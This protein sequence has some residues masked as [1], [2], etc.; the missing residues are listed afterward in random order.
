M[1]D[2]ARPRGRGELWLRGL[3]WVDAVRFL[4]WCAL[5]SRRGRVWR[6]VVDHAV[7]LVFLVLVLAIYVEPSLGGEEDNP[8]L[9]PLDVWWLLAGV[10]GANALTLRRSAPLA[11]AAVVMAMVA[12]VGAAP[13][14]LAPVGWMVYVSAFSLGRYSTPLRSLAGLGLFAVAV[15]VTLGSDQ[16]LTGAGVGFAVAFGVLAWFA[17]RELTSWRDRVRIEQANA[18]LRVAAERQALELAVADE[19]LRI[20]REVHD[21]VAHSMGL[22][23]VQA[24]MADAAFDARPDEARQAVRNILGTSRRSLREI[25]QIVGALRE[26]DTASPAY[27]SVPAATDLERLFA[28]TELQGLVVNACVD[29]E[30]ELPGGLGMSVYRIVQQALSNAVEHAQATEVHVTVAQEDETLR[31]EVSDNGVGSSS[32]DTERR[33]ARGF[34]IVGMQERAKAFGGTLDAAAMPGGGFR[35]V[36]VMPLSTPGEHV[37]DSAVDVESGA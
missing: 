26:T 2:A 37:A 31:V 5:T 10:V 18:D 34:G 29:L 12:L 6:R 22:I 7:P 14:D 1:A 13:Y 9:R 15:G 28:E 25:R 33:R 36:A 32:A 3:R 19:R 16:G 8:A 21:V 4:G 20:A 24:G 23:S 30:G 17:G 27:L 11:S 35:V